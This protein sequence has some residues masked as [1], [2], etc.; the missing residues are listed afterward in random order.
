LTDLGSKLFDEALQR[1]DLARP[2]CTMDGSGAIFQCSIDVG[3][4]LFD[5]TLYDSDI[6]QPSSKAQRMSEVAA[7]S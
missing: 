6:P 3:P 4:K 7:D 5:E 1:S 2:S